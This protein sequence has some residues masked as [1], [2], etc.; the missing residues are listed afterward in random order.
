MSL[1]SPVLDQSLLLM[2]G[3][4]VFYSLSPCWVWPRSFEVCFGCKLRWK[5]LWKCIWFGQVFGVPPD[6]CKILFP[7]HMNVH[8]KYDSTS[9][10][11]VYLF[12]YFSMKNSVE[13]NSSIEQCSVLWES[14]NHGW[15]VSGLNCSLITSTLNPETAFDLLNPPHLLPD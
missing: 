4:C 2:S 13:F 10:A 5:V 12:E 3:D 15:E 6:S 14:S 9:D 7:L 8:I 1:V 11:D